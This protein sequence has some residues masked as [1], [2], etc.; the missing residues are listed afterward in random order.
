MIVLLAKLP[1]SGIGRKY[2]RY[3][4]GITFNSSLSEDASICVFHFHRLYFWRNI[5]SPKVK[6]I[7]RPLESS[8]LF[9]I[10]DESSRYLMSRCMQKYRQRNDAQA[11]IF[12]AYSGIRTL[13]RTSVKFFQVRLMSDRYGQ[14]WLQEISVSFQEYRGNSLV[15]PICRFFTFYHRYLRFL[16]ALLPCL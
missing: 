6:C 1:R 3:S 14:M 10:L 7:K 4:T 11:F 8:R 12:L 13:D 16:R 15:A 9:D 2:L 5:S